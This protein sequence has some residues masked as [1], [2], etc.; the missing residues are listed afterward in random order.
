MFAEMRTGSNFLEANLNALPGVIC[1]G[2]VF[3]PHF[4]G[5]KDQTEY[6]GVDMAARESDPLVLLRKLREGDAALTGFRFFHDHDP[7]VLAAV[8]P[9]PRV[10]QDHPDPQ[11]GRKLCVVEDRPG[12][13]A[14][15]ADQ[16]QEPAQCAGAL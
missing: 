2:E 16:C 11:S 3:N 7:R 5:K 4:I 1:H 10:R 12:H 13:R 6:L 14:V 8:L 15:E 9:D